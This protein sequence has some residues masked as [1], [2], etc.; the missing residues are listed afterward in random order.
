MRIRGVGA[1]VRW[2]LVE[3]E[4]KGEN[5]VKVRAGRC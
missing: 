5:M 3:G 2:L 4:E 1:R